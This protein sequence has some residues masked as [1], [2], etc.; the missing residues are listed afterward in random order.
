[1]KQL[2]P[3]YTT[4]VD[5]VAYCFCAQ[6]GAYRARGEFYATALAKQARCC[7]GCWRRNQR[8][9]RSSSAPARMLH[10]LRNRLRAG[11]HGELAR[12]WE[13]VDVEAVLRRC[14]HIE[15]YHEGGPLS[16]VPLDPAAPLHPHNA[17]AVP[18]RRRA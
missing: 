6:C 12:A 10:S 15:P 1:M 9:R 7:K 18:R 16:I 17:R 8:R 3:P 2:R 11:G 4:T 13:L 5:G 14:G